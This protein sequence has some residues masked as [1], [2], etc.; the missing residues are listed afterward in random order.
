MTVEYIGEQI[1]LQEVEAGRQVW[2]AKGIYQNIHALEID[3]AGFS[4]PVWSKRERAVEY[5]YNAILL[6]PKYEPHPVPLDVFTNA[7]LSDK[8]MAI[9]ELQINP[10]GKETRVLCLTAEEFK[11]TQASK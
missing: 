6:E 5:L 2:V 8:M 7:W 11:L 1:F 3:E 9:S 4:L 10:D